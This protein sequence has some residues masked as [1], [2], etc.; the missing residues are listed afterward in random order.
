MAPKTLKNQEIEENEFMVFH[1]IQATI[2]FT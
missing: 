1:L 2:T